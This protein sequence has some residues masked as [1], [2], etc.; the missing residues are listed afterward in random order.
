MLS[1]CSLSDFPPMM[2]GNMLDGTENSGA[3]LIS[4]FSRGAKK[5]YGVTD[6]WKRC[7][8]VDTEKTKTETTG[9]GYW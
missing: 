7:G 2:R 4:V 1:R 3:I 8:Q 9:L 6:H 5:S